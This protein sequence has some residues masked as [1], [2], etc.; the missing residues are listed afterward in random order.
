MLWRVLVG[1]TIQ[2]QSWLC[3][4]KKLRLVK[5]FDVDMGFRNALGAPWVPVMH[6]E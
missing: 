2:L 6:Q 5:Y 1:C 3:S 4:I